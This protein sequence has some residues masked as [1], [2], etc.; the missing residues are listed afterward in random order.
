MTKAR[1]LCLALVLAMGLG[2]VL[3]AAEAGF[4]QQFSAWFSLNDENSSTPRLGL[5]YQP[6]LSL[7]T[8]LGLGDAWKL[9]SEFSLDLS[10]SAQAAD[11]HAPETSGRIR[12]YRM[13]LRL[14]GSRFE[15]RL[16][17]QKINFG[18]AAVFRPLM[19]FD[20][21]DARDPTQYSEGVYAALARYVTT[22]NT[23][24]SGWAMYGNDEVRG[25]DAMPTESGK[26]EFGGRVQSRMPRGDVAVTYHRRRVDTAAFA[27]GPLD[28]IANHRFGAGQRRKSSSRR[29]NLYVSTQLSDEIIVSGRPLQE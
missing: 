7:A 23:S 3:P 1:R 8:A 24:V 29:A 12:F 9:D 19:W 15:A 4:E 20:R 18:S 13:W 16:G 17:L 27:G 11:W 14:A 22:G 21:V 28:S 25:W 5:R 26:P 10:A 2:G 6:A